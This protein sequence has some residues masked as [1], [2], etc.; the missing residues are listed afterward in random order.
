MRRDNLRLVLT[1]STCTA[2]VVSA[3][4]FG[5]QALANLDDD[6][7][8]DSLPRV[9]PYEGVLDLDGAP[10]SGFMDMRFTFFDAPSAGNAVWTETWSQGEG[11]P[12]QVFGG[13]FGAAL[14]TFDDGGLRALEDVIADAGPV[15]LAIEVKRTEEGDEAWVGL[16]GRQ[17]L[18]P[19]PYA[20]WSAK[21]ADLTVAGSA[22]VGGTL[23]V[24]GAANIDGALAV[25]GDIVGRGRLSGTALDFWQD[26]NPARALQA[27]AQVG[28]ALGI[29]PTGSFSQIIAGM[30]FVIGSAGTPRSLTVRGASTFDGPLSDSNGDL[31]IND[32]LD[33]SGNVYNSLA[34]L[35][36]NDNVSLVGD[37]TLTGTLSNTDGNVVIADN[38]DI[39]GNVDIQGT[40]ADSNSALTINDAV[41]VTGDV[42]LQDCRLC[43]L[44][45]DNC[46][47]NNGNCTADKAYAC[48]KLEHGNVSGVMKL[49]DGNV[50]GSDGFKLLF[51]CDNGENNSATNRGDAPGEGN[52]PGPAN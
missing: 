13:K 39:R 5:V 44:Y 29:D 22:T 31:A 6:P 16:S 33:V 43:I 46:D 52:W 15:Y 42:N 4:T 24:E 3:L 45:G 10:F 51:L 26:A 17:R 1:T 40:V 47:Q 30:N 20:L 7:A 23:A 27:L 9:V 18:N 19:V 14:G 38:A 48:V 28:G 11:R 8:T 50:D 12:I 34:N 32:G 25:G 41:T 21:A 2:I 49:S 37:L 35:V 36:L